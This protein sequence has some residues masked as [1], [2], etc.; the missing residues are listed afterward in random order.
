MLPI[1]EEI[2]KIILREGS[3]IEIANVARKNGVLGLRESGLLKAKEGVTSLAEV[4]ANTN[5]E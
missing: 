5:I 1:T 2:R 3:E 4:L